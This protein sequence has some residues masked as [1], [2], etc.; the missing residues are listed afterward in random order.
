MLDL[1]A[2]AEGKRDPRPEDPDEIIFI[3]QFGP[4]NL[5]PD[6]GRQ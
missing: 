3:E 5:Q 2:L 1:Y 6:Q 4:L